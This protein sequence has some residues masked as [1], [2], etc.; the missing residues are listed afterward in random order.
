MPQNNSIT[1]Q[2]LLRYQIFECVSQVLLIF[3]TYDDLQLRY[4]TFGPLIITADR[5]NCDIRKK[6]NYY[7]KIEHLTL[8]ISCE[9]A[10]SHEICRTQMHFCFQ[11]I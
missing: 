4:D 7:L 5:S 2:D 3:C 8:Q 11:E 6:V 9:H 10:L 1:C